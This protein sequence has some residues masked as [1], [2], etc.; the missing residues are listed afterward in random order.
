MATIEAR[1]ALT[2]TGFSIAIS[3]FASFSSAGFF[4][5]STS[6]A[7]I[8]TLR[9]GNDVIFGDQGQH[10]GQA[11][12]VGP[13]PCMYAVFSRISQI[14]DM[15]FKIP[16]ALRLTKP[17]LDEATQQPETRRYISQMFKDDTF[18]IMD[19]VELLEAA[20]RPVKMLASMQTTLMDIVEKIGTALG[21][22][23]VIMSNAVS[24]HTTGQKGA[25]IHVKHGQIERS[26]SGRPAHAF[27]IILHKMQVKVGYG[28]HA[29]YKS[30]V[31]LLDPDTFETASKLLNDIYEY[32]QIAAKPVVEK[33]KNVSQQEDGTVTMDSWIVGR[34]HNSPEKTTKGDAVILRQ[35]AYGS[36]AIEVLSSVS[37]LIL[38]H[39][40][41]EHA[42]DL[43]PIR[44]SED[45]FEVT[46]C[47]SGEGDTYNVPLIIA[48]SPRA[49]QPENK[50]SKKM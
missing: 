10:E 4:A 24:I 16:S 17:E 32:S 14:E 27:S 2:L 45:L 1:E 3:S 38:G 22:G 34:R 43:A 6:I 18:Q 29:V 26:Q 5:S 23:E 19:F 30:L 7:T 25:Y 40:S 31:D 37:G 28:N 49:P 21:L 39:L 35:S 11:K 44:D 41:K 42:R 46:A 48:Y 13:H 8:A 33:R 15:D 20:G 12:S 9:S 36:N 47:I 50:R